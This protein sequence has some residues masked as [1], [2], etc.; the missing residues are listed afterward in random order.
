MV[1]FNFRKIILCGEEL[2]GNEIGSMKDG[3]EAI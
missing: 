2:Q 1:R 3:E